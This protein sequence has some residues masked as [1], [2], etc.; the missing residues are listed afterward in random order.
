[1]ALSNWD[2]LAFNTQGEPCNGVIRVDLHEDGYAAVEIYKNWLYVRD[3]KMWHDEGSFVEPT[4]ADIYEGIVNISKFRITAERGPQQAVF[5]Y[6]RSG[7][8]H[9]DNFECMCGIGCYAFE[10][11]EC[12]GVT[13]ETFEAF[14]A[15]M[16]NLT[17]ESD[18]KGMAYLEKL[19]NSTPLRFN[20]GDGFF[21]RHLDEREEA[22]ATPIGEQ[23]DPLL[24]QLIRGSDG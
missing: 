4:V 23:N 21:A 5:A 6:V 19:R 14:L 8:R 18:K 13:Q 9:Q 7:Y 11:D 12:V 20:Q 3:S 16:K 1:M 10:G 17:H 15:F 22:T 24:I 2:T